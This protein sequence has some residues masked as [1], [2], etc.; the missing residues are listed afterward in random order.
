MISR[1]WRVALAPALASTFVAF[2][3]EAQ[4]PNDNTMNNPATQSGESV[5]GAPAPPAN[6]A[7]ELTIG[8]GYTQGFGNVAPGIPSLTDE[9]TAG[10]QVQLGVA[11]R[12]MPEFALGVYGSGA[13]FGRGATADTNANIFGATFGIQ[14][15][16]HFMPRSAADPWVSLGTGYRGY[17]ENLP[18]GGL[19]RHGLELAKVQVGLDARLSQTVSVGPVIGADASIYLSQ[20]LPTETS[21]Y[22]ITSPNVNAYLF[23][24][25]MGRFD[26]PTGSSTEA[27]VASAKK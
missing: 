23:G 15:D 6:K 17:W 5:T 1:K 21:Y 25:V 18:S 13:E 14:A 16:W 10:G 24:G 20:S 12:F 2:A 11:Y 8:T 26:I 7:V 3:A 19:S 27:N 9:S 4:G 22:S